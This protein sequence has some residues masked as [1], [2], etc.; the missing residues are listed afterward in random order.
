MCNS[1]SDA[2]V[3]Q[4]I[5]RQQTFYK[6]LPGKR[7]TPGREGE[8]VT[9]CASCPTDS[10]TTIQGT[11]QAEPCLLLKNSSR[12]LGHQRALETPTRRRRPP[13]WRQRQGKA[14]HGRVHTCQSACLESWRLTLGTPRF[15][16]GGKHH[17]LPMRC[18]Q[19]YPIRNTLPLS[20]CVFCRRPRSSACLT[21]LKLGN[22]LMCSC[23]F[24]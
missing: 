15:T 13:S 19:H 5:P 4:H 10:P 14:A 6:S 24:H 21:W 1:D 11:S 9:G 7:G 23:P 16:R 20:T 12:C 22:G 8:Y 2:R 18:S 3:G 17:G